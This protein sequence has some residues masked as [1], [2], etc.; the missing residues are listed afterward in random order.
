MS[1]QPISTR[2]LS[3]NEK[4]MR[5]KFYESITAQSDLMDKLSER[6]L[7]LEL[8]IP[9]LYATVLKLVSGDTATARVN[10]ALYLTFAC[11]LTAL[12]LTLIALAPKKWVVDPTLLKQDPKKFSEGLGIE[13]FF[14]Q[15]ALYKRR[16]VTASSVLFFVGIFSAV[17]TL[18]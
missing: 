10:A 11:W 12:I 8:A 6:L 9:G 18:G 16:L 14:E 1:N 13:D 4:L 15:S 17:F 3:D 7:T 2:P 5:E